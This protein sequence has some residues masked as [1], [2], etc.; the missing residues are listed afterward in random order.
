M[1]LGKIGSFSIWFLKFHILSNCSQHTVLVVSSNRGLNAP[2]FLG[3]IYFLFNFWKYILLQIVIL[4]PLNSW[5][6]EMLSLFP[7]GCERCSLNLTFRYLLS[8]SKSQALRWWGRSK[9]GQSEAV[10]QRH[11]AWWLREELPWKF[12]LR[13]RGRVASH[14]GWGV[15]TT[16]PPQIRSTEGTSS[17]GRH[18]GW[19]M[20]Y[21]E[22]PPQH[23]TKVSGELAR[24]TRFSS[25]PRDMQV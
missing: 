8:I 15:L 19:K 12:L 3:F 5:T 14:A 16:T 4:V 9:P 2:A 21:L 25:S 11:S 22:G 7:L 20:S 6:E 24:G 17:A 23:P 1:K 10:G 18:P 13:Q